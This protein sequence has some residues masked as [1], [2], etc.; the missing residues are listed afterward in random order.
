MRRPI[1]MK[2]WQIG[3]ALILSTGA[4]AGSA[5]R[6]A[7]A[8]ASVPVWLSDVEVARATSVRTG[9]PLFVAFR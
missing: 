9:K 2:P 6:Q 3:T 1:D 5:V 7:A 4:L 8:P